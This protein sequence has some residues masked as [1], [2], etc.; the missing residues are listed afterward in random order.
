MVSIIWLNYNSRGIIDLVLR[1]LEA[2]FEL[3]YPEDRYEVIVVD[4]GSNDGSFETIKDF[5]EKRSGA[6]KK[7]VRLERNLGFTGGNNA[8]FRARD[9]DARYVVLLNND[10]VPTKDSLRNLVEEMEKR[11]YLGGAQGVVVHSGTGLIDSAGC[12]VSEYLLTVHYLSSRP[13]SDIMRRPLYI[14]YPSG[15]YSIWRVDAVLKAN[16]AERL[17]Y[18]ELFAYCDDNV[19]A[20]KIWDSGYKAAAFPYLAAEHKGSATFSK[21]P[22]RPALYGI[23]CLSFLYHVSPISMAKRFVIRSILVKKSLALQMIYP[24]K[25]VL[26]KIWRAWNEGKR[27]G[28]RVRDSEGII[29]VN[30]APLVKFNSIIDKILFLA[31]VRYWYL[32]LGKKAWRAI[33]EAYRLEE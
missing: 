15:A 12:Y 29:D 19:L 25:L 24:S 8:G 10:A 22:L 3:D 9:V 23:R 30:K 33:E 18:D 4:N 2:V 11:P 1:S 5:V 7:I 21:Y 20:L 32:N 31:S 16:K 27:L 14:S 28:L 26:G 13:L 6:R 17:F